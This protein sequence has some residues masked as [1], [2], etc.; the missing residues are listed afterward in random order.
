MG[1]LRMSTHSEG[2]WR[3]AALRARGWKWTGIVVLPAS[4]YLLFGLPAFALLYFLLACLLSP[5][6]SAS[7]AAI[8][9][10]LL[11][12]I[13][14]GDY[15]GVDLLAIQLETRFILHALLTIACARHG[16]LIDLDEAQTPS[17]LWSRLAGLRT[18][19]NRGLAEPLSEFFRRLGDAFEQLAAILRRDRPLRMSDVVRTNGNRIRT[20][21]LLIAITLGLCTL[22]RDFWSWTCAGWA[23][24][25]LVLR[26]AIPPSSH[27]RSSAAEYIARAMLLCVSGAL[28]IGVLEVGLRIVRPFP[29]PSLLVVDDPDYFVKL[30][31]NGSA[32]LPLKIGYSEVKEIPVH[33]SSQ[34]IRDRE[35]GTKAA[36]EFRILLIGDSFTFGH[37]L[38][39]EQTISR[40]LEKLL[41]ERGIAKKVTVINGGVIRYGPWQE[42]GFLNDRGFDFEP[43][44]VILQLFPAN[45][46]ANTLARDGRLLRA[47]SM[48]QV[49]WGRER[50]Y[51]DN[52]Q[53]RANYWLSAH[54]SVFRSLCEWTGDDALLVHALDRFALLKPSTLYK[55]HPSAE[56]PEYM[57]TQLTDWYGTLQDG[58]DQL[59][60]DVLGI[61]DDCAA[62][63]VDF[64]VYAVPDIHAICE[65]SWVLDLVNTGMPEIY[66]KGKDIDVANAFFAREGLPFVDIYEPIKNYPAPCELYFTFDWHFTPKG[67]TFTA[68]TIATHLVTGYFP[69]KGLST[70][71]AP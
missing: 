10:A 67:A 16:V 14:L 4:L 1:H 71:S 53:V 29:E 28:A 51:R 66:T 30:P 2:R 21:L 70:P 32:L 22:V 57:E 42:R 35:Y 6:W 41:A 64:M 62:R 20:L 43:D 48:Q 12:A 31:P 60:Q 15:A 27:V 38:E 33:T 23:L 34:G 11:A 61:R 13:G 7:A 50:H 24:A 52:W 44:L 56:R 18:I 37:G 17:W 40:Q 39:L 5:F 25:F 45:D 36:D 63:D 8:E 65:W 69:T 58:W 19:V 49:V 46:I 26:H 68:E 47:Y 55:L 9:L 59:E 3:A 54:S